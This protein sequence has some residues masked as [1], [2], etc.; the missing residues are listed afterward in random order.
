MIPIKKGA[1]PRELTE[2]RLDN[3][4]GEPTYDGLKERHKVILESLIKEQGGLC[5]YCMCRIPQNPQKHNPPASIEHIDPQSTSDNAKALD[6]RNMLAVC[7]GNRN[8][9]SQSQ[10][11]LGISRLT[12]DA[13]RQNAFLTV[14]PL[15]PQTLVSIKYKHNGI[16]YSE[17]ERVNKDLNDV[18]NLNCE[19][20]QLPRARMEAKKKLIEIVSKRGKADIGS[21]ARKTIARWNSES[22]KPPYVGILIDWLAKHL[23]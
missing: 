18:L 7:S 10:Y 2:Y 20:I 13:H 9:T 19:I 4:N 17:D 3:R 5:A 8:P 14:N 16:I 1:E 15:L 23:R 6:Y 11:H 21:Y 22:Q 12:C